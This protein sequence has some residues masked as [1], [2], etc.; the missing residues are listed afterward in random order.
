V[1]VVSRE[2]MVRT[3]EWQSPS[4]PRAGGEVTVMRVP[5]PL[6]DG[7]VRSSRLDVQERSAEEVLVWTSAGVVPL[8]GAIDAL[9]A[10]L[11][12]F[13]Q[14][15]AAGG[16]ILDFAGRLHHAGG[17]M[18][19]DAS[20]RS[21]GEGVWRP[22]DPTYGCVQP[23]DWCSSLLMATTRRA[24]EAAGGLDP[25]MPFGPRRDADF[26][27]RLQE[28]GYAICYDP[29][30]VAVCGRELS[31]ALA[32]PAEAADQ[33]GVRQSFAARWRTVLQSRVPRVDGGLV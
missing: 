10:A 7:P 28:R 27:L 5:E 17:V 4:R 21:R 33:R 22:D 13:P 11:R 14:A 15:G 12:R 6:G 23:V 9:V 20:L 18:G 8:P 32:V 24:F 19:V 29:A 2:R 25:T 1:A 30:S 26:C 16:R 31:R 3:I